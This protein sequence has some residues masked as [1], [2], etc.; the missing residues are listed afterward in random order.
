MLCMVSNNNYLKKIVDSPMF[1]IYFM[2]SFRFVSP[3]DDIFKPYKHYLKTMYENNNVAENAY[4]HSFFNV[5]S[6]Y[7]DKIWR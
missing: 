3:R 4:R 2:V 6:L 7:Q 5:E 1:K